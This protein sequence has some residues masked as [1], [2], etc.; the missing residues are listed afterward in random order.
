I[1]SVTLSTFHRAKGLEWPVVYLIGLE[2]GLVPLGPDVEEERRLLYVGLTRAEQQ[3][4]CSW[5]ARRSFG[6]RP[7][8]RR[9]SP[10]LAAI[11]ATVAGGASGG[12]VGGAVAGGRAAPSEFQA[13][14]ARLRRLGREGAGWIASADGDASEVLVALREWRRRAARDAQVAPH[15][16]CH[17]ATLAALASVR[18]STPSELLAVPGLGPV[19]AAR[20]GEA[21]L[22]LV[23]RY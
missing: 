4:H 1:D 18:P 13:A 14:R 5:A 3:A 8:P 20:Y 10:W 11:E 15:V 19:K 22:A 16:V 2:E 12:V 7:V 17:D 21:L 9:P 6:A 23:A